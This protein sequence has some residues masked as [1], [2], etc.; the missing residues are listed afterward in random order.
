MYLDGK[1]HGQN[2]F[3]TFN[4]DTVLEEGL[5]GLKVPFCYGFKP[6]TVNFD[7]TAAQK[8]KPDDGAIQVL[9]LHGS[10]NWA[11]TKTPGG[12][13]TVFGDYDFVRGSDLVPELVPPTW[14][15]VFDNQLEA[16]WEAAVEALNTA[17]RVIIIGFSMPPTDLHFKYLV[18]AGLQKNVSLR[19]IHFVNPQ[20]PELQKRAESLLRASYIES[21]LISFEENHVNGC[22]MSAWTMGRFGRKWEERASYQ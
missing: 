11:R 18:A 3:I 20:I 14:K 13:L 4:Y 5:R 1:P 2:T 19:N 7:P 21:K 22:A 8:E 12:R 6:G 10:V 17:T 15:K 16:V 9:K